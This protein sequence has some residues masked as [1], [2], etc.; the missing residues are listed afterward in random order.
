VRSP[1]IE[2]NNRKPY[3]FGERLMP[4]KMPMLGKGAAMPDLI[5]RDTDPDELRAAIV[6]D[7]LAALRPILN[8][9]SK[10]D[11]R[12]ATRDEMAQILG[13]SLAK[14]DRETAAKRIP[15][16]LSGGRRSYVIEEGIQ[17]VKAG[18]ADAERIAAARQ[19]EKHARRRS[20]K[21]GKQ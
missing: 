2:A 15:S 13:W 11:K 7:V 19:T 5:F 18:T 17:A 14:L 21:G 10:I 20:G 6:A 1:A 9:R 8:R 16:L 4:T 3:P 12:I